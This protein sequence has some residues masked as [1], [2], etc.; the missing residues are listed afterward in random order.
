MYGRKTGAIGD[1]A[2]NDGDSPKKAELAKRFHTTKT[3]SGHL[4]YMQVV[5]HA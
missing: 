1:K 3:R 5:A 2:D 4:N